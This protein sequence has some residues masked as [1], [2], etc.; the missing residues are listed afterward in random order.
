ME[1]AGNFKKLLVYLNYLHPISKKQCGKCTLLPEYI[2]KLLSTIQTF[3]LLTDKTADETVTI[4]FGYVL[5]IMLAVLL[6]S[7]TC[8]CVHRYIHVSKQK[9][10]TN[11]VS[12]L[13]CRRSLPTLALTGELCI[14]QGSESAGRKPWLTANKS[15]SCHS[16]QEK[17][18]T[19]R[20]IKCKKNGVITQVSNGV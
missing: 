13:C 15:S 6:I 10:P 11:L 3:V 17:N 20:V 1:F 16:V 19:S 4:V 14:F 8:Y 5:P 9:H 18:I 7:M 2:K 12:V